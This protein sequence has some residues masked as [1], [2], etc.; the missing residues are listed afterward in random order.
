MRN[1]LLNN[2]H[3]L[4]VVDWGFSGLYPP[5]FEFIGMRFA[6]QKDRDPQSWQRCIKY[7]ADPAFEIEVWMKKIGYDLSDMSQ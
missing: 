4:W 7:M 3:V 1:L 6:A 2:H 5:W